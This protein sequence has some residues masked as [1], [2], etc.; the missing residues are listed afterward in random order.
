MLPSRVRIPPSPLGVA[1][2]HAPVAQLDRALVY[3][4]KG[5]RFESSPAHKE[6]PDL[7]GFLLSIAAR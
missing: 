1:P 6:S 4:T 5:R 3:E 2:K 7:R